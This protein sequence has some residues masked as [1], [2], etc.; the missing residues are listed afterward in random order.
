MVNNLLNIRYEDT[1]YRSV[2]SR[3][4]DNIDDKEVKE[5]AEA[6]AELPIIATDDYFLHYSV[7]PRLVAENNNDI[8][9]KA[10][11]IQKKYVESD[12]YRRIKTL[13]TLDDDLSMIH[14]ISLTKKIVE[15]I[16]KELEKQPP[17]G[18][19]RQGQQ[20]MNQL[21]QLRQL[22]QQLQQLQ[23]SG[24][25]GTAVRQQLQQ[26][27][28]QIRQM[29]SNAMKNLSSQQVKK[30]L[31]DV[32]KQ[33]ENAKKLKDIGVGK[34]PGEFKKLLNLSEKI[35]NVKMYDEIITYG[36]KLYESMTRFTHIKKE[37]ARFGDELRGY[38]VTRRVERALP[39]ELALPEELVLLKLASQGLLAREKVTVKEGAFYVLIDKSGSMMGE[40]TVW[41]R[42]VALAL[43]MLAKRKRRKY[44][45]RFFDTRVYPEKPIT[46][47]AEAIEY[48]LTIESNGG[49]SIDTALETAIKDLRELKEYTNT[50]II[51]TDGEDHVATKPEQLLRENI[52]LIAVMIQGHNE[53]LK[54]LAEKTKGMYTT[55]V[56]TPDGALAILRLAEKT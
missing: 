55:A 6:V 2:M 26:I 48:I 9:G 24:R 35:M 37:I 3:I 15:V 13:T 17:Q 31:K 49:T 54:Q 29:I 52:T 20:G 51:I 39:R 25:G 11:E 28:Q 14:A 47:P 7:I 43:Y 22:M 44:F 33:T 12:D 30:I 18:G 42:S 34:N 27:K 4:L 21:Q 38:T 19:G 1:A 10:L 40:K 36:R 32:N 46:N 56:L 16:K 8:L 53:S 50:I 23:Q 45:L 5:L 41:A